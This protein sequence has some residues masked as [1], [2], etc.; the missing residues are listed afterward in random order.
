MKI[1][2]K[3]GKMANL[4]DVF[5]DDKDKNNKIATVGLFMDD[6]HWL[7]TI[8]LEN[9]CLRMDYG[10]AIIKY[11][12][13]NYKPFRISLSSKTAHYSTHTAK[14]SDDTRCLTTEGFHLAK[15]CFQNGI[16][17]KVHFEFPYSDE[18]PDYQ[19]DRFLDNRTPNLLN[20]FNK[21]VL[22][23]KEIPKTN[24]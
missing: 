12:E 4:F 10:P 19:N 17:S 2:F 15:K 11:L 7:N 9:D 6:K 18:L 5:D 13:E 14:N 3:N 23:I 8:T 24:R 21:T 22:Q 1:S 20:L 16:L